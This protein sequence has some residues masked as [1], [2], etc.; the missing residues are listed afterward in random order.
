MSTSASS[1]NTVWGAGRRCPLVRSAPRSPNIQRHPSLPRL[2]ARR[3]EAGARAPTR[4]V[5][6]AGGAGRGPRY[7]FG[8]AQLSLFFNRRFLLSFRPPLTYVTPSRITLAEYLDAWIAALDS[9]RATT[10]A[11]SAGHIRRH[12]TPS[13]GHLRLQTVTTSTLNTFYASLIQDGLAPATVRRVHSTVHRSLRDAVRTGKINRNPA[14]V[15]EVPKGRRPEMRTW[16]ADQV[17]IFLSHVR[18]DRL[19]AL[20]VLIATTGMRRGEALAL[21]WDDLDLESGRASV[22]RALFPVGG[23]LRMEEPKNGRTR[24]VAL[25]TKTVE[26]L[27]A[28]RV[29]ITEERFAMG[30]GRPLAS[31]LAFANRDGSPVS[32]GGLS[33]QFAARAKKAN[34]PS[35]RLHDLRHTHATL[36]LRA[37]I[38]PKVVQER[39]G[40]SSIS[41]TLDLYSHAIP[42]LEEAAAEQIA[43]LVF[44]SPS[45]A[46]EDAR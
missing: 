17:R 8:P 38:H 24:S 26:T 29:G 30:L 14:S 32:P 5:C 18:S 40:H 19:Y 3:G 13:L 11:S 34:L 2:A 33:Q 22:R 36:A 20:W 16:T 35:I 6:G 46:V 23:E 43:G 12:V 42:G 37:G 4:A 45:V 44:D 28:H 41:L 31:D 1:T 27:R 25:D 15:A 39:L 10:R 21:R 7:L 9:V